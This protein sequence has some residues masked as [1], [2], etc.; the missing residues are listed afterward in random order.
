MAD[1]P[2]GPHLIFRDNVAEDE[3]T[4]MLR[5][6]QRTILHHPVAAQ[7]LFRWLVTE[8]RA[9]AA[10]AEGQSWA[11]AIVDSPLI[12][13]GRLIWDVATA[14]ALDD[15]PDVLLPSVLADT[16]VKFTSENVLEPLLSRFF[17]DQLNARDR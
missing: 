13:R 10:T 2:K 15:D 9:F 1:E 12:R 8:G 14:R 7:A 16:F 4:I 6:L 11:R 3:L 17:E 5:A